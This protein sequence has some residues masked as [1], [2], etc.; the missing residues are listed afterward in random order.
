MKLRQYLRKLKISDLEN[1]VGSEEILEIQNYTKKLLTKDDYINILKDEFGFNL[2]SEKK[3]RQKIIETF[4]SEELDFFINFS[5]L[6]A[7]EKKEKLKSFLNHS[8]A[9]KNLYTQKWLEFFGLSDDY[10]PITTKK[11][12]SFE[13]IEA[14]RNLYPYQKKIKDRLVKI[15]L[16]EKVKK[17]LLHMPTGAGKTRT[18]IEAIVDFWRFN[19]NDNAYIVWLVEETELCKQAEETF[20][21][22]WEKRGDR[23]LNLIKLWGNNTVTV[24][25]LKQGGGIVIAGFDK[26]WSYYKKPTDESSKILLQIKRNNLLTIIDEAHKVI[27]PTYKQV[28]NFLISTQ[29][30]KVLGLTAT[31]GRSN[32]EEVPELVNFFDNNKITLTDDSGQD[33]VNPIQF[34]QD[35]NYLSKIIKE[36]IIC[37]EEVVLS[38]SEKEFLTNRLRLPQKFLDRLSKSEERTALIINKTIELVEN[39]E[40]IIIFACSVKHAKSLARLLKIRDIDSRCILGETDQITRNDS[41]SKFK[42]QEV[43]ILINYGVLTTGF[44]A[45]KTTAILITRPTN[46]LV[47]YSQ[48]IGRGIRGVKMG[49]TKN[50]YLVDIVDNIVN[51]PS[52]AKAF[53]NFD[54]YW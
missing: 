20:V 50:C 19:S 8:W 16:S 10:L 12:V 21:E 29:N 48:M 51:Y 24:E 18:S 1:L 49:G 39:G 13:I 54:K 43:K 41:I 3:V 22:L 23:D 2:L 38:D 9:R 44:D 17:I 32:I 30:T 28:T 11:E 35:N 36:P 31:P 34:L 7:Q 6:E 46:S 52:E 37:R 33:M 26:L 47:L 42:S 5:N 53:L 14:E 45:P 4:G 25:E 15:L 27:A 40:S